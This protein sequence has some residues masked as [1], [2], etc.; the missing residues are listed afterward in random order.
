MLETE[1]A[2]LVERGTAFFRWQLQPSERTDR[3]MV[4]YYER[5]AEFME[6]PVLKGILEFPINQ[7]TVMVALRRRHR[8]LPTPSAGE[9]WG[10]GPLVRH[11][12]RYWEDQDFKF[13]GL[14][15]WIPQARAHLEAGEALA[16][17]RLLMG[18]VWDKMD[19]IAEGDVFSFEALLAYLFKWGILDL[20][21]SYDREDAGARFEELVSEV[22]SEQGQP[23]E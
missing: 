1:D 7:R 23:F 2:E 14:Y 10:V 16:L 21:L 22:S 18:L 13:S 15:P 9:P 4:A 11:I 6:K 20:W 19:R 17:D 8:G 5:M 12:E 3:E